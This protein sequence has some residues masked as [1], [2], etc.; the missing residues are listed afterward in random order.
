MIRKRKATENSKERKKE[1]EQGKERNV[2]YTNGKKHYYLLL[3]Y[4]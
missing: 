3:L 1:T 2:K 4:F